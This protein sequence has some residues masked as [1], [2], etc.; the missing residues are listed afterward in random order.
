MN[1]SELSSRQERALEELQTLLNNLA[2]HIAN[3][4]YE[5]LRIK[6]D[7]LKKIIRNGRN[8]IG[9]LI[10]PACL[11]DDLNAL[12]LLIRLNRSSE[13]T[14]AFSARR[15]LSIQQWYVWTLC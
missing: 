13:A 15:S 3:I 9:V 6:N 1:G 5:S 10:S 4:L 11:G 2:D 7:F 14:A 8:E 12:R